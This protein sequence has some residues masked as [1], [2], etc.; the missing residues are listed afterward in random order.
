[1]SNINFEHLRQLDPKGRRVPFPLPFTLTRRDGSTTAPALLMLHAGPSNKGWANASAAFAVKF[2]A[3]ARS[4]RDG[5]M[6]DLARRRDLELFPLHIVVGWE[7]VVDVSGDAVSFSP[8]AC[9]D[10]F[11]AL[12]SHIVDDIRVFAV[13]A[14]NFV[15]SRLPL[16][17]EIQEAAGN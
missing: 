14:S 8:E 3:E 13:V 10:L 1:M 16:A 11:A 4:A 17:E 12:P 15:P 7:G 6:A 5:D 9:S 2:A